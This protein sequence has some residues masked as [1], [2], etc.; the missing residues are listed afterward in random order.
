MKENKAK[1][2]K[3]ALVAAQWMLDNIGWVKG[4]FEKFGFDGKSIGFC[5]SGAINRVETTDG[6]RMRAR[7]ALENSVKERYFPS[8]IG[9]NDY[10]GT[11]KEDVDTVIKT[12]IRKSLKAKKAKK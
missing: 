11:T 7:S 5:L 4:N 9:F 1:T 6:V 2:V 8:I 10:I 12:A 3:Q